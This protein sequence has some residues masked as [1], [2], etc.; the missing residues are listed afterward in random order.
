MKSEAGGINMSGH[1]ASTDYTS[2]N[3]PQGRYWDKTVN[4]SLPVALANSS[5]IRYT[6][7]L[8]ISDHDAILTFD[9]HIVG[10]G[11]V[12]ENS[13]W[14]N[15][16]IY[17]STYT[18]TP[19]KAPVI[20]WDYGSFK[21]VDVYSASTVD[22][23]RAVG[24]ARRTSETGPKQAI[25]WE[26]G[27]NQSFL[28]GFP[29]GTNWSQSE[30]LDINRNGTVVGYI[31]DTAGKFYPCRWF[32]DAAN[33][34]YFRAEILPGW[35][36]LDPA[37]EGMAVAISDGEHIC[38]TAVGTAQAFS[39]YQLG[40]GDSVI[41][42]HVNTDTGRKMFGSTCW[43]SLTTPQVSYEI[44]DSFADIGSTS[45]KRYND[46]D[47]LKITGQPLA[48]VLYDATPAP[49]AVFWLLTEPSIASGRLYAAELV[50]TYVLN[51]D[52]ISLTRGGDQNGGGNLATRQ[53]LVLAYDNYSVWK[54]SAGTKPIVTDPEIIVQ[55]DAN[56]KGAG[57]GA[58]QPGPFTFQVSGRI[59][60]GGTFKVQVEV[61]NNSTGAWDTQYGQ[62]PIGN[63]WKS[64]LVSVNNNAAYIN[65]TLVKGRVKVWKTI[66]GSS[67]WTLDMDQVVFALSENP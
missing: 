43:A 21:A 57:Q 55:F 10:Y 16:P 53:S 49:F 42:F 47:G 20:G 44:V 63:A 25:W 67:T 60:V 62:Q 56:F 46:I 45:G 58:P 1:V 3:V 13:S 29:I 51:P 28:L 2:G 41:K 35:T 39:H 19:V 17:W 11:E 30:A 24:E 7:A 31:T 40:I 26:S 36:G 61:Y 48:Q 34:E 27:Q 22:H 52:A 59:S 9:E 54:V 12:L 66:A 23:V 33:I 6:H 18:A 5:T 8:D 14:K 32:W 15:K 37:R 65:G 38:G 50:D 64:Y 4:S